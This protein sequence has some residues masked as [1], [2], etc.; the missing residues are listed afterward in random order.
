MRRVLITGGSGFVGANLARRLLRDGH[1]V[2]LFL[3]PSHQPWR[4]R[5]ISGEVRTHAVDLIDREAVASAVSSIRPEW[6][7][8]LA[9]Y[10]GYANQTSL[11][12]MVDVNLTGCATL[13]DAC[14]RP[15]VEAF[16]Q[17]GTSSEYGRK[18]HAA[19]EEEPLEPNSSYAITKAAATHYCRLAARKFGINTVVVRLYSIFGPYEEPTRLIPTLIAYGLRGQLPPLVSPRA[20]HDFV[21]VDDAIEVM[22]RA[23]ASAPAAPGDIYNV[24]TGVQHDLASVVALACRILR[25]TAP[26]RWSSMPERP[27]DTE[28]WTGSPLRLRQRLGFTCATSLE[29]GFQRTLE[30]FT[31]SPEWLRGL[32]AERIF[33]LL[34]GPASRGSS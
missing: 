31:N 14:A 16:V 24:C 18:D 21:Y 20:A 3:R 10:G 30:W 19:S 5:E 9:A 7:F 22:L 29:Q 12:R 25:V 32:Y 34:S 28:V 6:V 33:G 4:I 2:H 8:N 15:G 11:P 17:A 23:A 13:L 27:W 1:Q 26:P